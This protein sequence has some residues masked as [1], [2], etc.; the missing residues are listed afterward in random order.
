M[1]EPTNPLIHQSLCAFPV[2]REEAFPLTSLPGRTREES[3][4]PWPV[5]R[6]ESSCASPPWPVCRETGRV[7]TTLPGTVLPT[8]TRLPHV[9]D[10]ST[11]K[12]QPDKELFAWWTLS[13]SYWYV[14]RV[15]WGVWELGPNLTLPWTAGRTLSWLGTWCG[16]FLLSWSAREHWGH[17][18]LDENIVTACLRK[19]GPLCIFYNTCLYASM[20]VLYRTSIL[21][22]GYPTV[23]PYWCH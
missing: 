5:Y 19:S 13:F 4:P 20:Q 1:M 8:V 17:A 23:T 11:G 9:R 18:R 22:H 15:G 7:V 21:P 16:F 2:Y 10:Q 14:G 3:S 12:S 6:E